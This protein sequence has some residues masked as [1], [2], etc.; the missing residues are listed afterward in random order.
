MSATIVEIQKESKLNAAR[1]VQDVLQIELHVE[2]CAAD[3]NRRSIVRCPSPQGLF[4]GKESFPG[5][6]YH[7]SFRFQQQLKSLV[8]TQ[9]EEAKDAQISISDSTQKIKNI[10]KAQVFPFLVTVRFGDVSELCKV[11]E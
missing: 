9:L 7:D 11:S 3:W 1:R 8:Q 6:K 10:I 5:G 2:I 4:C